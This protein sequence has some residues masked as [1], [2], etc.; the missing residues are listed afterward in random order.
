MNYPS[1]L[2]DEVRIGYENKKIRRALA[3]FKKIYGH[4]PEHTG[5]Y[6]DSLFLLKFIRYAEV[7]ARIRN[8]RAVVIIKKLRKEIC[9][10]KKLRNKDV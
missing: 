10:L 4:D 3:V 2:I 5:G 7:Y 1:E 6:Y 8:R 9:L